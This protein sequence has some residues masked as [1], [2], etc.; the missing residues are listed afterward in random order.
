VRDRLARG[1]FNTLWEAK[2]ENNLRRRD[3]LLEELRE[4]HK[5]WPDDA[6]VRDHLAGGLMRAFN[7]AKEKNELE[8]QEVLIEELRNL[9]QP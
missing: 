8:R 7:H 3:D 1:L 9:R 5:A 2:E 6:A 4:L